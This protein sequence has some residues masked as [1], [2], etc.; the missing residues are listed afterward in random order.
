MIG[1]LLRGSTLSRSSKISGAA[2]HFGRKEL[3]VPLQELPPATFTSGFRPPL[4]NTSHVPFKIS[5]TLTNNLP[6]YHERRNAGSRKRTIV[7]KFQGNVEELSQELSALLG[8]QKV[9]HYT[10]KLEVDG[11]HETEIKEWLTK[12]GF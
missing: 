7:R 1:R 3:T 8:G 2:L 6:V 5:R 11:F 4:G 10:G 9:Y 12:L